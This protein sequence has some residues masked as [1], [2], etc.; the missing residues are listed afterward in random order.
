[1]DG[2]LLTLVKI[3]VSLQMYFTDFGDDDHFSLHQ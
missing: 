2:L 3:M 1:M